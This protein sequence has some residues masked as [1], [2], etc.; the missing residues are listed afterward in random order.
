MADD[1]NTS[2]IENLR[3]IAAS[4]ANAEASEIAELADL[5]HADRAG[6]NLRTKRQ[7]EDHKKYKLGGMLVGL[8]FGEIDAVAFVGLL[9]N[10]STFG[11]WLAFCAKSKGTD[12]VA[13][14]IH[15]FLSKPGV[16]QWL[17]EWG[18]DAEYRSR[19]VQYRASVKGFDEH[20]A[21]SAKCWRANSVTEHQ[22]AIARHICKVDG[23]AMPSFRNRGAAYDWIKDHGGDTRYSRDRPLPP[24]WE[25]WKHRS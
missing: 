2:T 1:K 13:T 20:D 25:E 24:T 3:K 10:A 5:R 11:E 23:I 22:K 17:K 6:Q 12:D 19:A 15:F 21:T 14:L 8:G 4:A 16:L 18:H 9:R 7:K